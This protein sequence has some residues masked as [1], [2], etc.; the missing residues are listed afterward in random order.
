MPDQYSPL[1]RVRLQ[2]TGANR[3]TWGQKLNSAALML[4]EHAIAGVAEITVADSD[5]T[6]SVENGAND[7]ARMAVLNLTGAPGASRNI[8]V[9][10]SSKFYLV[11]NNTGRAHTVKTPSGT[12]VSVPNGSAQYVYCD[13]TNVRAVE[14]TA[15][16]GAV[17]TATNALALGGVDAEHYAR[18]DAFNQHTA[19]FATSFVE[20]DDGPAI[21]VDCEESNRFY[22]E[23]GGDR[24]LVLTNA[25]DGQTIQIWFEQDAVGNRSISWPSNVRFGYGT[26]PKLSTAANAIDAYELTYHEDLDIWIARAA[27]NAAPAS[28]A[29]TFDV[30]LTSNT[31]DLNLYEA[32]GRP[33]GIVTVNFTIPTGVIV[34]ASSTATP[35]LDTRGFDAGSVINLINQGFILGKG[36]RGGKGSAGHVN[37]SGNFG[38]TTG[39]AAGMPGGPA[40]VGPGSGRTLNI[41]NANGRIYGGGGGGGGG[42]ASVLSNGSKAAGGGGGGGAGGGEGGDGGNYDGARAGS[43]T[44]GGAGPNGTGGAGGAGAFSGNAQGRSGGAGGDWGQSGSAGGSTS[45]FTGA[46]GGAGGKAVDVNGANVVFHSGGTAPNVR[47]AVS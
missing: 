46:P 10:A 25:A 31:F 37:A 22:V 43:G 33:S 23:L 35:A 13:G 9:P 6:L 21:T 32:L 1:L 15:V 7:E 8:V 4:F 41:D 2:A 44:A 28:G 17:E 26:S 5:V 20:L 16:G 45:H 29:T 12:G 42:E 30:E 24:S 18:K 27:K 14:A 38:W 47:G 19:G 11:V 34:Q 39:A 36:G 40:I 3:N